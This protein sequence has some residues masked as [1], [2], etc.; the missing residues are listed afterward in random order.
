MA[1]TPASDSP[2][3]VVRSLAV[4][5]DAWS[6]LILRD[7]NLG[8]TRFEQF[9]R[10][11]GIAPTLLTR[12]LAALT[13]EGLLERRRYSERPPRDEY[14]PTEAGRD[15]LPVLFLIGAWGRRHRGGGQLTRFVDAQTG[16]EIQPVAID[17][18]TGAPI[19]TRDIHVAAA[20]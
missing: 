11:L 18:T 8:L 5:G 15:V 9:R 6:M 12:R 14:L 13:D 20:R 4:F 10:S 7:A 16:T 19:G 17:A 3:P 1:S 2:C